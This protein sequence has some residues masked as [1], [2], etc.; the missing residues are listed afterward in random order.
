MCSD[1]MN[2][3]F[4]PIAYSYYSPPC[5]SGIGKYRIGSDLSICPLSGDSHTSLHYGWMD[6][7]HIGY[8]DLV[9]WAADAGKIVFRS[10]SNIRNYINL[11]L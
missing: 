11:L 4:I 2:Y 5:N 9:P 8:Q 7:L 10:I 3:Y 6:F 1:K